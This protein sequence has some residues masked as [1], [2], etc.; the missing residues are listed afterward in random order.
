M[1]S[2]VCVFSLLSFWLS[3]HEVPLAISAELRAIFLVSSLPVRPWPTLRLEQERITFDTCLTSLLRLGDVLVPSDEIAVVLQRCGVL[4]EN[5]NWFEM[6]A[7]L[8]IVD[9]YARGVLDFQQCAALTGRQSMIPRFPRSFHSRSHV[10]MHW[11]S[12]TAQVPPVAV[13]LQ[14]AHGDAKPLSPVQ[15]S[16]I[17]GGGD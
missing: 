10:W 4:G 1:G 6:M 8:D 9:P 5:F 7:H 13:V 11:S 3:V 2:V 16:T 12:G 17:E 15:N 14:D